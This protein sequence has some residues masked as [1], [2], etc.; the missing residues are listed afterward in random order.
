MLL[1]GFREI[2]SLRES[3]VSHAIT[4]STEDVYIVQSNNIHKRH[5][6]LHPRLMTS[7]RLHTDVDATSF[8]RIDVVTASLRRHV[9]AGHD[10]RSPLLKG[11][12]LSRGY[13][14]I[15]CP[16]SP[17]FPLTYQSWR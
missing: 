8:C 15:S 6:L 2:L 5:A 11:N 9:S 3:S 1:P 17:V 10:F 12:N 7:D 14:C 16:D 13:I 4:V